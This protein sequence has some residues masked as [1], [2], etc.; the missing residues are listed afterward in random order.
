MAEKFDAQKFLNKEFKNVIGKKILGVRPLVP[1]EL[2]ALCWEKNY[3]DVPFVFVLEGGVAMIPMCDPEGNG[4]GW[5]EVA[6]MR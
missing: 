4:A 3:G 5:I 2:D 6:G 1:E